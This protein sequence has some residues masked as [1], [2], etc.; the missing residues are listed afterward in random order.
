MYRVESRCPCPHI[1]CNRIWNACKVA[2][3]LL[4]MGKIVFWKTYGVCG[5]Q[6]NPG[7]WCRL[8]VCEEDEDLGSDG[9][10][11]MR[12]K[13]RRRTSFAYQM[14]SEKPN[15]IPITSYVHNMRII[16]STQLS[17]DDF[18]DHHHTQHFSWS[19]HSYTCRIK[20]GTYVCI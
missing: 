20:L 1:K 7:T 5:I 8:W 12:V 3:V 9:M 4:V 18:D 6:D 11:K 19:H 16:T 14:V 2:Q 10:N 15:L 17:Y 13:R